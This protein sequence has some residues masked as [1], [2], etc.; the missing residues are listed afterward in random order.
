MKYWTWLK[1]KFHQH[2]HE[3]SNKAWLYH[4]DGHLVLIIQLECS[5]GFKY[6]KEAIIIATKDELEEA[7]VNS[8][9]YFVETNREQI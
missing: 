4:N 2:N 1:S 9:V 6:E 7:M 5:C 3:I 8:K